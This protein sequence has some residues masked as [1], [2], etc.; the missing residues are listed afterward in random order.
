MRRD[1]D[2]LDLI[3][4]ID[5]VRVILEIDFLCSSRNVN[6]CCF[7]FLIQYLCVYVCVCVC[8]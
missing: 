2:L 7:M 5:V 4:G 1:K 8:V 3:L 6:V